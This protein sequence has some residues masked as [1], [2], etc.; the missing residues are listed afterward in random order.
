MP[1]SII[2]TTK[3]KRKEICV[4]PEPWLKNEKYVFWPNNM[5]ITLQKDEFSE[6]N[7]TWTILPCKILNC[8]LKSYE[9][10]DDLL[11]YWRYKTDSEAEHVSYTAFKKSANR[12]Y[13][14]DDSMAT[15]SSN[16]DNMKLPDRIFTS[17]TVKQTEASK[18]ALSS[19][20]IELIVS[21]KIMVSIL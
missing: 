1:W 12:N 19:E 6:T 9:E 13:E 3:E 14:M 15:I 5:Q 18:S 4:A 2:Q 21:S 17:P 11:D 7:V 20:N 8:G 10:A 16:A